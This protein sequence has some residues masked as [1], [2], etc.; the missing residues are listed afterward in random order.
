LNGTKTFC[1]GATG[2]DMLNVTAPNPDDPSERV[3]FAIPTKR[4]GITVVADWDNLGQRQ[5]DSGS[6]IFDRVRVARDEALGPPDMAG[7]PRATL[8]TLVS[9]LILTEIFNGN[10]QGALLNAWKYTHEQGRPWMTSGVARASD[11][12]FT[13]QRY[14]DLWIAL[15]GAIALAVAIYEAKIVAAR[16]ALDIT[17]KIFEVMGARH[18]GEIWFR[19]FLAQC[20]RAYAAR[21]ARLQ[22]QGCRRPLGVDRRGAGAVDLFL[23]VLF[24]LLPAVSVFPRFAIAG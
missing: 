16:A 10:A 12:P 7:T 20:A 19:P 8:R 14:G 23:K 9:Q 13:Q 15:R 11:D 17:S 24:R 22:A 1:S 18:G 4:A 2:S 6:V 5:T 21:F 3:F